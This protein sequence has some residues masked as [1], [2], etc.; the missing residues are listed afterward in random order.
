MFD[1]EEPPNPRPPTQA[2]PG[3]ITVA[4]A[5]PQGPERAASPGTDMG[6]GAQT[7]VAASPHAPGLAPAADAAELVGQ[8]LGD[9]EILDVLGKGGFGVVYLARQI[10]LDRHVALKVSPDDGD[11]GRSM[12]RLEHEHIVQV[13]SE[14]AEPGTTQRLL[15]MQWVPGTT[16]Q[17][18]LESV[19]IRCGPSWSGADL[20]AVIDDL[21][22]HAVPLDQAALRFRERLERADHAEAV[23]QLIARVADALA[24]AHRQGV[25]HRD[26][27][28]G[29]ILL[30]RYGRPF[31]ADFNLALKTARDGRS[32]REMFGGTLAYMSPE[33]LDALNPFTDTQVEAVD[34]RSDLYALGVVL[35]ELMTGQLPFP[36]PRKGSDLGDNLYQLA[37]Q[38]RTELPPPIPADDSR[39]RAIPWAIQ[40]C[41]APRPQDRFQRA[42]E[43]AAALD[44][45]SQ[46]QQV[47]RQL[48]QPGWLT[49]VALSHPIWALAILALLPHALASA[50]SI[51]Y[52][53]HRIVEQL[54]R[55]HSAAFRGLVYS[56]NP[57]VYA[58]SIAWL[59]YLVVPLLPALRSILRPD[60]QDLEITPQMRRAALA[61]PS[62][63]ARLSA[64]GWF[65]AGAVFPLV[66]WLWAGPYDGWLASHLVVSFALSGLIAMT[67]SFVGVQFVVLR[68]LY[69]QLWSDARQLHERARDE[70][71]SVGWRLQLF[72]IL[73]G[74][75]PLV[76]A[77]LIICVGQQDFA[78]RFLA[79]ALVALGMLGVLI[80]NTVASQ[81][82]ETLAVLTTGSPGGK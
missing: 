50:V 43:L 70:L 28:P 4:A 17:H 22:R 63:A 34:E 9:Y 48:P 51:T 55:E 81:L 41:L 57:V 42:D 29:N 20:I 33:H 76:G 56:Y 25:L 47:T 6:V 54:T 49:R 64:L 5:P 61:L 82:D 52:N 19:L 40:R 79:T 67:Y 77:A 10:A 78:F 74:T 59:V 31:L 35:Y 80:S 73:A 46:L 1:P 24:Y 18:A 16:L 45:C 44:G 12:A 21:S 27:K 68:V 71:R 62:W 26:I 30:N 38:R 15:C 65:S 69:P 66:L 11:E 8:R 53:Y 58:L 37:E 75:I 39:T 13:Y 32:G 14:T 23:C 3:D 7:A 72:R 2:G 36:G 60:R